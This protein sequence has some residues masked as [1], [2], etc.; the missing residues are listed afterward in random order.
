[1]IGKLHLIYSVQIYYPAVIKSQ[2][3]VY[4]PCTSEV[5][6]FFVTILYLFSFLFTFV[7]FF[8]FLSSNLYLNSK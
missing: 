3:L 4:V 5:I 8:F 1:M 6:G 7:G 2:F